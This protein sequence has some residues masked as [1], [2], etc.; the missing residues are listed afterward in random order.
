M[1]RI[2]ENDSNTLKS[3]SNRE[4]SAILYL[5][6]VKGYNQTEIAQKVYNNYDDWA[7]MSISVVTRGFGFHNGRGRG[8][9]SRVSENLINDFVRQYNPVRYHGGLDEGTFDVFLQRHR[10]Q[11]EQQQR[12]NE[13]HKRQLLAERQKRI[14]EQKE[15]RRRLEEVRARPGTC[16]PFLGAH[17]GPGSPPGLQPA[18][19]TSRPS[20][21]GGGQGH[22]TSRRGVTLVW[23]HQKDR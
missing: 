16:G 13:E 6:L 5:Y 9:Y 8:R 19:S 17:R 12:E 11:L 7:S 23:S 1:G 22:F 10:Q 14:E 20:C 18:W 4:R 21:E 2:T 15:Q 3:I